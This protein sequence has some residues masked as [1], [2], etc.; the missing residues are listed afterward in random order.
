M[1]K[2]N[3]GLFVF[4]QLGKANQITVGK[5]ILNYEDCIFLPGQIYQ[6]F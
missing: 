4:L 2:Q 5:N 3:L 1:L 6:F